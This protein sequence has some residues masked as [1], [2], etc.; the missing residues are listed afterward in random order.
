V[1]QIST[2]P[3]GDQ[4]R[5]CSWSMIYLLISRYLKDLQKLMEAESL[6]KSP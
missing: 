2:M 1:I 3:W 6:L 4:Q 5:V